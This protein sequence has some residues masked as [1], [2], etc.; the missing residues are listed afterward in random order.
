MKVEIA[1]ETESAAEKPSEVASE[2]RYAEDGGAY[3]LNEF[4]EY[5]GEGDWPP[6]DVLMLAQQERQ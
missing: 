4:V 3:T 5:F 6:V 1:K 2:K